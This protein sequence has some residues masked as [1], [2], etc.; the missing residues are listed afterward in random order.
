MRDKPHYIHSFTYNDG[1][2]ALNYHMGHAANHNLDRG[3]MQILQD[4]LYNHHPGVQLYVQAGFGAY[5]QHAS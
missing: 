5:S 4:T 1:N 3:T 2:E